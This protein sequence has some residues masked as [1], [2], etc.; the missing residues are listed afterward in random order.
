MRFLLTTIIG[1]DPRF[2]FIGASQPVGCR[3]SA[4]AMDPFWFAGVEPWTFTRQLADHETDASGTLLPL[5]IMLANPGPHG[6]TA[7][8][9]SIVSDQQ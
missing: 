5:P 3:Y 1:I 8:P 6:V 7:V 4:L 2:E 9:G